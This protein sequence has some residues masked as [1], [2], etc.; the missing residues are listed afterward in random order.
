MS[1]MADMRAYKGMLALLTRT[2]AE[3]STETLT[4]KKRKKRVNVKNL[5]RLETKLDKEV[6]IFLSTKEELSFYEGLI[7]TEDN[8]FIG[9]SIEGGV[10]KGDLKKAEKWAAKYYRDDI[11]LY[12]QKKRYF[13]EVACYVLALVMYQ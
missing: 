7:F 3:V 4:L 9:F 5:K 11:D 8:A 12:D 6:G 13:Y 2:L 10:I 1:V